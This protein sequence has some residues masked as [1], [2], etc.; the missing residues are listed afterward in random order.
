MRFRGNLAAGA[1]KVT[2]K[3]VRDDEG[4][5]HLGDHAVGLHSYHRSSC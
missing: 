2:V 1:D 5:L 4:E 3:P